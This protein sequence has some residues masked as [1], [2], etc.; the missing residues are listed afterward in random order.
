MLDES[1]IVTNHKFKTLID[2]FASQTEFDESLADNLIKKIIKIKN[3]KKKDASKYFLF[4]IISNFSNLPDEFVY[5]NKTIT[6]LCFAFLFF[7]DEFCHFNENVINQSFI[8]KLC[9]LTNIE[10]IDDDILF[11]ICFIFKILIKTKIISVDGLQTLALSFINLL[12]AD[13]LK[14]IFSNKVI[15][16]LLKCIDK[17]IKIT[18]YQEIKQKMVSICNLYSKMIAQPFKV[19]IAV[20]YLLKYTEETENCLRLLLP[21]LTFS[22]DIHE[23][24]LVLAYKVIYS[25]SARL[26][27]CSFQAIS[28]LF[29][30]VSFLYST[31]YFPKINE[32]VSVYNMNS[33]LILNYYGARKNIDNDIAFFNAAINMLMNDNPNFPIYQICESFRFSVYASIRNYQIHV[34]F[35]VFR[36]ILE[37][38]LND[39]NKITID[40]KQTS[41]ISQTSEMI[42]IIMQKYG[43]Y[44]KYFITIFKSFIFFNND[45]SKGVFE[46]TLE[47]GSPAMHQFIKVIGLFF[48]ISITFAIKYDSFNCISEYDSDIKRN[49]EIIHD[50]LIDVTNIQRSWDIVD[51]TIYKLICLLSSL[52]Y[53]V[54][55]SFYHNAAKIL[56]DTKLDRLFLSICNGFLDNMNNYLV[57]LCSLY[58]LLQNPVGYKIN[59]IIS[60]LIIMN[61]KLQIMQRRAIIKQN[62]IHLSLSFFTK[63]LQSLKYNYDKIRNPMKLL[64]KLYKNILLIFSNSKEYVLLQ[65]IPPDFISSLY[66]KEPLYLKTKKEFIKFLII[67][68]PTHGRVL[69]NFQ[70]YQKFLMKYAHLKPSIALP[71]IYENKLIQKL[72]KTK[73]LESFTKRIY[74]IFDMPVIQNDLKLKQLLLDMINIIPFKNISCK[75]KKICNITKNSFFVLHNNENSLLLNSKCLFHLIQEIVNGKKP[76]N[77]FDQFIKPYQISM[78]DYFSDIFIFL[79]EMINP[80]SEIIDDPKCCFFVQKVIKFMV[81]KDELFFKH[82]SNP[83]N[84]LYSHIIIALTKCTQ[85]NDISIQKSID[86]DYSSSH[87][88]FNEII[89]CIE[90]I[91]F[92]TT[93]PC[94][95]HASNILKYIIEHFPKSIIKSEKLITFFINFV[96]RYLDDQ[97]IFFQH[98]VNRIDFNS[99]LNLFFLLP[100]EI[101]EIMLYIKDFI[102]GVDIKAFLGLFLNKF[103]LFGLILFCEMIKNCQIQN[104]EEFISFL[105]SVSK[106]DLIQFIIL[107]YY[108]PKYQQKYQLFFS[109]KLDKNNKSIHFLFFILELNFA[110]LNNYITYLI[111]TIT[112]KLLNQETIDAIILAYIFHSISLHLDTSFEASKQIK[113]S[114]SNFTQ[115]LVHSLSLKDDS[116][117]SKELKTELDLYIL[118]I[119]DPLNFT[120][121]M[122]EQLSLLSTRKVGNIDFLASNLLLLTNLLIVDDIAVFIIQNHNYKQIGKLL[123]SVYSLYTIDD[124]IIGKIAIYFSLKPRIWSKFLSHE[125]NII[126]PEFTY[127]FLDQYLRKSK[128]ISCITNKVIANSELLLKHIQNEF[129]LFLAIQNSSIS[130]ETIMQCFIDHFSQMDRKYLHEMIAHLTINNECWDLALAFI[131]SNKQ[132]L[133][134]ALELELSNHKEFNFENLEFFISKLLKNINELSISRTCFLNFFE[135]LFKCYH[136]NLEQETLSK[137]SNAFSDEKNKELFSKV[138]LIAKDYNLTLKIPDQYRNNNMLSFENLLL[139]D[140]LSLNSFYE[141]NSPDD[142]DINAPHYQIF[143]KT[144]F[145]NEFPRLLIKSLLFE[146]LNTTKY[147]KFLIEFIQVHKNCLDNPLIEY[148][149][150]FIIFLENSKKILVSSKNSYINDLIDIFFLFCQFLPGLKPSNKLYLIFGEK[151]S[152]ILLVLLNHSLQNNFSFQLKF[153]K[154]FKC[155]ISLIPYFQDKHMFAEQL[156]KLI[157]FYFDKKDN[158]NKA[159]VQKLLKIVPNL[160]E[161]ILNFN[162]KLLNNY[163]DI[164]INII[165]QQHPAYPLAIYSLYCI[166]KFTN[167]SWDSLVPLNFVPILE[168]KDIETFLNMKKNI[169]ILESLSNIFYTNYTKYSD[170]DKIIKDINHFLNESQKD[171]YNSTHLHVISWLLFGIFKN[172]N[173]INDIISNSDTINSFFFK[174]M[175]YSISMKYISCSKN[176]L[177]IPLFS[178]LHLSDFKQANK[179]YK[180]HSTLENKP[181]LFKFQKLHSIKNIIPLIDK[182]VPHRFIKNIS[183]KTTFIKGIESRKFQLPELAQNNYEYIFKE[184]KNRAADN[185]SLFQDVMS[186]VAVSNR[187]TSQLLDPLNKAL[188]ARFKTLKSSQI[189]QFLCACTMLKTP[190]VIPPFSR[191]FPIDTFRDFKNLL[192]FVSSKG[193]DIDLA[194]M[195]ISESQIVQSNYKFGKFGDIYDNF[196]HLNQI[197][198]FDQTQQNETNN[199]I[200]I[201]YDYLLYHL[202]SNFLDDQIWNDI[203]LI[204]NDDILYLLLHANIIPAIGKREILRQVKQ[205]P[206]RWNQILFDDIQKGKLESSFLMLIHD[207]FRQDYKTIFSCITETTVIKMLKLK[208]YYESRIMDDE[209]PSN[210]MTFVIKPFNKYFP[211]CFAWAPFVQSIW[212]IHD[213]H[214]LI[215]S[216]GSSYANLDL[217]L[218]DGTKIKYIIS[219]LTGFSPEFCILSQ[220]LTKVIQKNVYCLTNHVKIIAPPSIEIAENLY[221]IKTS[222][223]PLLQKSIY[224]HLLNAKRNCK[225]PKP[226]QPDPNINFLCS[227]TY[228]DWEYIFLHHFSAISYFQLGLS[229]RVPLPFHL[230]INEKNAALE[231]TKIRNFIDKPLHNQYIRLFGHMSNFISPVLAIKKIPKIMSHI[232]YAIKFSKERILQY[233]NLLLVDSSYSSNMNTFT[234]IMN[235]EKQNEYKTIKKIIESSCSFVHISDIPWY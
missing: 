14:N 43:R 23:D 154:L 168:G 5:N 179:Q 189:C 207:N 215:N 170:V 64:R 165:K 56:F 235:K 61:K 218:T 10:E 78:P 185:Y 171:D 62:F 63:F 86:Y 88:L 44:S 32:L 115:N 66:V 164:L 227:K 93:F 28:D 50:K 18:N 97:Y 233:L 116:F 20:K 47:I 188:M 33:F 206:F 200:S 193:I 149:D 186:I 119:I 27:L 60:F 140:L 134:Q 196:N 151:L 19:A 55:L 101:L 31:N 229:V 99:K 70:W 105:E 45:I 77:E 133:I 210:N 217:R 139:A 173:N 145:G 113:K 157:L 228:Y 148:Y 90:T 1:S 143:R 38:I 71:A 87:D 166:N 221:L 7:Q 8:D 177:D 225:Y 132:Y 220:I 22:N 121:I 41:T 130:K 232:S 191:Y 114:I 69:I 59:N 102:I 24:S 72:K 211:S 73:E 199:I 34:I 123:L 127:F 136:K 98:K 150:E 84:K 135:F 48:N 81:K 65:I 174:N 128:E 15:I 76:I 131:K 122:I 9:V 49:M 37:I 94:P 112:K 190:I 12:E 137:I 120:S 142:F 91:L 110:Y 92:Q 85:R 11:K 197:S 141:L 111:D 208:S 212:P 202:N 109:Q 67:I 175:P 180:N 158:K 231:I 104:E 129:I 54:N 167:N 230:L 209:T 213:M 3:E 156:F 161:Y 57:F 74:E 203:S 36:T 53:N 30:S 58:M 194:W 16:S 4:N 103:P 172:K 183:H 95:L 152:E 160:I 163:I 214:M 226:V 216:P 169:K 17:Y 184:N 21:V 82:T 2:K 83:S 153:N 106:F 146:F 42:L 155:I 187:S 26:D 89:G 162:D 219:G 159:I 182:Y 204:A 40:E 178:Y 118:F 223:K 201:K 52:P 144:E 147:F 125:S 138:F 75:P 222:A 51:F 46:T 117:C 13:C 39:L 35:S 96:L 224:N 29:N 181:S 124:E 107:L 108:F 234:D 6:M 25:L 100:D 68:Y 192:N 195:K 176:I 205:F 198:K 126:K 79:R 80:L